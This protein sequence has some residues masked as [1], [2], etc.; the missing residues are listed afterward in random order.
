[1]TLIGPHYETVIFLKPS[2]KSKNLFQSPQIQ[3]KQN[4]KHKQ[5]TEMTTFKKMHVRKFKYSLHCQMKHT[6]TQGN[7]S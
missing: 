6:R 5:T 4:P 1:V 3:T 2:M 7:R